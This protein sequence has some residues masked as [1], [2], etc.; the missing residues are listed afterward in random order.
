MKNK[1]NI[2][3]DKDKENRTFDFK[4]TVLD[5]VDV[6]GQVAYH[7]GFTPV[8]N[9]KSN[10]E[11]EVKLKAFKSNDL[12]KEEA[13]ERISILRFYEDSGLSKFSNPAMLYFKKPISG[14]KNNGVCALEIIGTN[15]TLAEA[16][17]IKTTLSI[18]EEYK[19]KDL[20]IEINCVGD[21]DS[22]SKFEKDL[23]SF[24]KKNSS[25]FPKNIRQKIKSNPLELLSY[26]DE[27]SEIGTVPTPISCLSEPSRTYFG[28]VLDFLDSFSVPYYI[29]NS[30]I[31]NRNYGSHL[32]FKIYENVKTKKGDDKKLVAYGGRYNYFAKKIGYKKDVSCFGSTV[33]YN[34]VVKDKKVIL[35]KTSKPKF[36]IMQIGNSAKL[37]VLNII[38][39]LRKEKIPVHHSLTKDKITSQIS[40]AEYLK[41]SHVLIIG[42]K[43]AID[44]TVIV[45]SVELRD[46]TNVHI[47]DLS[48]HLKNITK[49]LK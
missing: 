48:S 32:I 22:F 31:P 17:V 6:S 36:Y 21:K 40:Y 12:N 28:E 5:E 19:H 13:L 9:I 25:S 15:K 4:K 16:L 43:E 30:L 8:L 39:T 14:N 38:D 34:K 1:N 10:K 7:Y 37:K 46:Q 3:I 2:L 49:K 33:F 29:N 47:D 44:N 27:L 41:V 24:I 23:N 45:R 11:D 26:Q 18:L 20:I 35:S 42:Q